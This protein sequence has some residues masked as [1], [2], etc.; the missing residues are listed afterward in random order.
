MKSSQAA[1][2]QA[3]ATRAATAQIVSLAELRSDANNE[4]A[5]PA[6]P[7]LG[8]GHALHAVKATVSVCVGTAVLSIGELLATRAGEV[9]RL[10]AS[11]HEPVDLLVEGRVVAR[12]QLVAVDDCFAI[13]ITQA[14]DGLGA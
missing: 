14:P 1:E 3:S 2:A 11:L 9:L 4:A 10:D 12:G 6:A 7:R 13:R 5:T 8:E